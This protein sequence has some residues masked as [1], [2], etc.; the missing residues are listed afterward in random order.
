MIGSTKRLRA[1]A[2]CVAPLVLALAGCGGGAAPPASTV[3]VTKVAATP[4]PT[5]LRFGFFEAE[6]QQGATLPLAGRR[7]VAR[8]GYEHWAAGEREPGKYS[9]LTLQNCA[10][11]HLYGEQLV[12]S[13]AISFSTALSGQTS[14]IPAFYPQDITDPTTRAAA[15][16]YLRA[17]VQALLNTVGSV[18]LT[19]D[20]EMVSNW[21][22]DTTDPDAPARAATWGAWYVEAVAVARQAAADLG[23]SANLKLQPIV[24]GDPFSAGNP[25]ALGAAANAWLVDAVAVSDGLAVD[26]YHSDPAKPV[27]DPTITI[28]TLRFWIDGYSAGKPVMMTENG[29]DTITEQDPSVTRDQRQG[30]FTGTEQ[31]QADYYAALLP[32]LLEANAAGGAFHNQLRVFSLWSNVDNSHANDPEDVY[33]GLIRL[34]NSHKPAAAVVASALGALDADPFHRASVPAAG[35]DVS[36][37]LAA[38]VMLTVTDGDEYEMLHYVDTRLAPGHACRLRGTAA[39]DGGLL[40]HINTLWK[41]VAV[42]A[43]PF[44]VQFAAFDCNADAANVV[45]LYVTAAAFPATQTITDLALAMR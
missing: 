17:Y 32:A 10:V 34:D 3:T 6:N 24:N 14:T 18:T 37:A 22:L 13:V 35:V 27:T 23:M 44:D 19:I 39:S 33:F 43:G 16:A 41:Q 36:D 21:R 11:T 38:G 1:L 20:N 2:A 29:F 40:V 31:Q 8:A 15:K 12:A 30:K 28:D 26:S 25:I 5:G 4:N 45:D 7:P 9:F 42:K